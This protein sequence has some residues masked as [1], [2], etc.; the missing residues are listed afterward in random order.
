LS[1]GQ[2]PASELV[3]ELLYLVMTV[4]IPEETRGGNVEGSRE[5]GVDGVDHSEIF[6]SPPGKAR[7]R[8]IPKQSS[9]GK[10]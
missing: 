3:L 9:L 5:E 6:P 8:I 10:L 1:S 2:P 4:D 7:E